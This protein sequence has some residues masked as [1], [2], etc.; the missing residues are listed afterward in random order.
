MQPVPVRADRPQQAALHQPVQVRLRVRQPGHGAREGGRR[1]RPGH[2]AEAP[3]QALGRLRQGGVGQVERGP[4]RGEAVPLDLHEGEQ[5]GGA[6]TTQ[7]LD[8]GGGVRGRDP[9]R[10]HPQGQRHVTAGGREVARQPGLVPTRRRE[11]AGQQLTGLVRGQ[12]VQRQR[13]SAVAGDQSGQPVATRHHRERA[14]PARQQRSDLLGVAR[15]VQHDQH[16]PVGQPGAVERGRLVQVGGDGAGRFAERAQAPG[17]G[18]Q[19]RHRSVRGEAVQ[20]EKELAVR[21]PDR[22]LV[23]PVHDQRR[24]ADPAHAGDH[25]HP[26]ARPGPRPGDV[27]ELLEVAAPPDEPG[28]VGRQ[29]GRH[30]LL[31]WGGT[32]RAR[33]R[34]VR[35]GLQDLDG[36]PADPG[37]GV[38]ALLV[39][40]EL[41]VRAE[42]LQGLRLPA[43]PVQGEHQQ[44]PQAL[45][46]RVGRH[47]RHQ[48]GD[49]G[50][51]PVEVQLHRGELLHRAQPPLGEG[52]PGRLDERAGG[53]R[54]GF[55]PPQAE[56]L[57]QQPGRFGARACRAPI[58]ARA[59]AC[60]APISARARAC[61]APIS[62][63]TDAV[64]GAT[65]Q[66]V[67]LLEVHRAGGHGQQVPVPSAGDRV[68]VTDL[69]E[70]TPQLGDRV[71]DLGPG[72]RR[73]GAAPQRADDPLS[74]DRGADLEREQGEHGPGLC[75]ADVPVGAVDDDPHPPEH[76]NPH[77]H[78]Y[79][80]APQ[81]RA[82]PP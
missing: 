82:A 33:R 32:R 65:H 35:P 46:V 52:G 54:E 8:R 2:L 23:R 39:G 30:R 43:A 49:D 4:D 62:A 60:R 50:R 44:P 15:V 37:A 58:S 13:P 42:A 69:A 68:G 9:G 25:D 78:P 16:P 1:V 51:R 55:A 19:R 24:L 11:E 75:S 18:D 67:E 22:D 59:R 5:L 41:P 28:H 29:L 6:A 66:G 45:P 63:R 3:E 12:R 64:G 48:I 14:V 57:A 10:H 17:E 47:Q 38:E 40:E 53:V 36:Q 61:R 26:T 27:V 80:S 56:R 74:A 70:G 72:G 73:L 79:P 71:L 21:K 77:R 7:Q 31:W 34:V 20:V 76:D 81:Q